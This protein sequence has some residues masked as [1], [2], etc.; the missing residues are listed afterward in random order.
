M[1]TRSWPSAAQPPSAGLLTEVLHAARAVVDAE[2][3]SADSLEVHAEP[4]S[5]VPVLTGSLPTWDDVVR[6]GHAAA[7]AWV[8]ARDDNPSDVVVD[9][10]PES[11]EPPAAEAAKVV[12]HTAELPDSADVVVIGAGICGMMTAYYL[13]RVGLNVA[14]L[15]AA[16]RNRRD[17]DL[18]EQWHGPPRP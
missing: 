9:V 2:R 16:S 12:L 17:D 18:L 3:A 5:G 7:T 11:A 15:D 10:A 6:A 4:I 13:S 1:S 14:V 8:T